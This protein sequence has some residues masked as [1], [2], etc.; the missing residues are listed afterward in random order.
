MVLTGDE[1]GGQVDA[2]AVIADGIGGT[3]GGAQAAR[4]VVDTVSGKLKDAISSKGHIAVGEALSACIIEANELVRTQQKSAPELAS[5]GATCVAVAV[6]GDRLTVAHVGDSRAYL[7]RDRQLR[8]LTDDHSEVWQ[9]VKAGAMTP[10]QA[11]R[12]AF[13]NSITRAVGLDSTVSPDVTEVTLQ[14]DDTLLLCTDGLSAEV[15]DADL[16]ALLAAAPQPQLA[17]DRLVERALRNGGRDNVTVVVTHCSHTASSIE[18]EAPTVSPVAQTATAVRAEV[19]A[20]ATTAPAQHAPGAVASEPEMRRVTTQFER[21]RRL[22][23]T[24]APQ[25]A[26][27]YSAPGRRRE[28]SQHRAAGDHAEEAE[29]E[30]QEPMVLLTGALVGLVLLFGLVIVALLLRPSLNSNAIKMPSHSAGTMRFTDLPL[31]YQDPV[32]LTDTPLRTSTLLVTPDGSAVVLA[33]S[34]TRLLVGRDRSVAKVTGLHL[35]ADAASSPSAGPNRHVYLVM[36]ASGNAYCNDPV[37]R[38][39]DKFDPAGKLISNSIGKGKL[40]APAAIGVNR[41]GDLFVI[42]NGRLKYIAAQPP[43]RK[44]SPSD[45]LAAVVA[46]ENLRENPH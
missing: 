17:C 40:T 10:E 31:N 38:V 8:Q 6:V 39:I 27:S 29:T 36:D 3:G 46:A 16:A 28:S 18:S 25:A 37:K 4:I 44:P 32:T 19:S 13:R 42:D 7:L 24:D 9:E 22:T 14:P 20:A 35:P 30:A 45:D 5:M 26:S 12:S 15:P 23:T 43:H 1:L 21:R 34:G 41:Y 2:L 33:R 11:R